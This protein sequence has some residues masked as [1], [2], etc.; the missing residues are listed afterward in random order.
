MKI[1]VIDPWGDFQ[2]YQSS[3]SFQ[4]MVVLHIQGVLHDL[5]TDLYSNLQMDSEDGELVDSIEAVSKDLGL[6]F[7]GFDEAVQLALDYGFTKI[8]A[9]F[10][11]LS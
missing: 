2:E 9:D 8:Q 5:V 7:K 6:A 10:S 4:Q 1:T 11:G 3:R